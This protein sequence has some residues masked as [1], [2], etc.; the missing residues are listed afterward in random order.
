MIFAGLAWLRGLI[1]KA[2]HTDADQSGSPTP[3]EPGPS[4]GQISPFQ[5][6]NP[7]Q[8]HPEPQVAASLDSGTDSA[9]NSEP[10]LALDFDHHPVVPSMMA[11]APQSESASAVL[12]GSALEVP[13]SAELSEMAASHVVES[14][15]GHLVVDYASYRRLL[16]ADSLG[17][18][19]VRAPAPS[20]RDHPEQDRQAAD[21]GAA[22]RGATDQGV[23]S[24]LPVDDL[25]GIDPSGNLLDPPEEGLL[26]S[27]LGDAERE[28][29]DENDDVLPPDTHPA[30]TGHD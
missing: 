16:M 19:L 23:D 1:F 7:R 8:E 21:R 5:V 9:P 15:A 30:E 28:V 18:S 17:Q 10:V 27:H 14:P 20:G 22:D 6:S 13:G 29:L 11:A 12:D 26:G 4:A 2:L 24:D 25:D 3:V